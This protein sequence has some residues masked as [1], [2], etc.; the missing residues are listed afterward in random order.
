M[1]FSTTKRIGHCRNINHLFGIPGSRDFVQGTPE[2]I[3][4]HNTSP[5]SH[6]PPT[7]TVNYRSKE[8]ISN[9]KF[10]HISNMAT[11]NN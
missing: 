8:K 7:V 6:T 1:E 9:L 3:I 5:G 11:E 4:Q 10:D 2:T